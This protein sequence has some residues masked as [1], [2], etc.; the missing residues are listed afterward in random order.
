MNQAVIV[1]F[2]AANPILSAEASRPY[3]VLAGLVLL[4]ITFLVVRRRVG[5]YAW[6]LLALVLPPLLFSE[7]YYFAFLL[8][9]VTALAEVIGKFSDEP[10]K[11]LGTSHAVVYLLFNGLIAAF[12][13][14]VL[15]IYDTPVSSAQDKLKVVIAAGVGSMLIMRS[16]LFNI[17]VAREDVA[18]GPDQIIKVFFRFM[19]AEIDRVRAQTRIDFVKRLMSEIDFD[20]VRNY[21]QT[22]LQASQV[23]DDKTRQ[24]CTGDMSFNT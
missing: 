4:L 15:L 23:L 13:L 22:M 21:S 9:A 19:E 18:F 20:R 8:G 12:A 2:L 24:T 1:Q 5:M 10:T 6:Y 14:Y 11:A 7:L 17:K 3:L 16:K